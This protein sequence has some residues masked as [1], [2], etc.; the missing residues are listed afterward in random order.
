MDYM[1][2]DGDPE[3]AQSIRNW[4]A[5]YNTLRQEWAKRRGDS[6]SNISVSSLDSPVRRGS[7]S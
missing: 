2:A 6:Y 3:L 4:K 5:D 1:P 7:L